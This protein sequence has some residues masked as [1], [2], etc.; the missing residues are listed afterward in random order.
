MFLGMEEIPLCDAVTDLGVVIDG[1][2]RFD[3]QVTKLCSKI[4]TTR[5]RLHLLKFLTPKRVRLKLC[6]ALLLPYFF[7]C[8][9]VLSHLSSVDS[10]R[11]QVAFN[12]CTR[13]VFNLR[14]YGHLSTRRVSLFL[15][16]IYFRVLSFFSSWFW[17]SDQIISLLTILV[18]V[19]LE[20]LTLFF[21]QSVRELRC[22]LGEFVCGTNCRFPLLRAL[23]QRKQSDNTNR[24]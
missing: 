11:L 6:K 9:V 23:C 16:I 8:D 13:Y 12:S 17:R 3:R 10:R 15:I 7:Y 2:L 21:H 5:H 19:L 1:R 24:A 18:R 4:N 20:L 22:W 14:R